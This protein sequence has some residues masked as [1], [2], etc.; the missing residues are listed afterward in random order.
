[1]TKDQLL[2]SLK[3]LEWGNKVRGSIYAEIKQLGWYSILV[4]N[5]AGK[6]YDLCFSFA[7]R[8]FLYSNVID[9]FLS[10][11]PNTEEAKAS[12]QEHYNNLVLQLFN[13]EMK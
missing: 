4:D 8:T 2:A 11:Y 9:E 13:L 6:S 10:S 5:T 12:A 7:S 1:M 3:P